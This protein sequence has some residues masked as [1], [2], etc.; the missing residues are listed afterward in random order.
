MQQRHTK[1]QSS[2]P[3]PSSA[4]LHRRLLPPSPRAF[5]AGCRPSAHRESLADSLAP[6]G[7]K[8]RTLLT[9]ADPS[10][11]DVPPRRRARASP[12]KK[13]PPERAGR[14]RNTTR[15][16][17][18]DPR[19]AAE[20]RA[21]QPRCS[22]DQFRCL[23]E[24]ALRPGTDPPAPAPLRPYSQQLPARR[25]RRQPAAPSSRSCE[26]ESWCPSESLTAKLPCHR[27]PPGPM[28]SSLR[29][30]QSRSSSYDWS[31]AFGGTSSA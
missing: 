20:P 25:E 17:R 1:A 8:S 27:R 16:L 7:Q 29:L 11:A 12:P 10:S 6:P 21:A 28:P 18:G 2:L 30:C 24:R 31:I 3:P 26:T 13:N 22:A 19:H 15:S 9:P 4:R 5:A 14:P 23:A